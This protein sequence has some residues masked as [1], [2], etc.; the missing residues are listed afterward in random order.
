MIS[1]NLPWLAEY[2][3]RH[4]CSFNWMSQLLAGPR[5]CI[6]FG[7]F[8]GSLFPTNERNRRY[9]RYTQLPVVYSNGSFT[10]VIDSVI[11]D[12]NDSLGWEWA[13][14]Y[15]HSCPVHSNFFSNQGY[16]INLNGRFIFGTYGP[17][18]GSNNRRNGGYLNNGYYFYKDEDTIPNP[19]GNGLGWKDKEAEWRWPVTVSGNYQVYLYYEANPNNSD[20]VN[21]SLHRVSLS[22]G[23]PNGVLARY[24]DHISQQT[25][26]R[27]ITNWEQIFNTITLN[28]GEM[29]IVNLQINDDAT[30][31]IGDR[32]VDAIRFIGPTD[33]VV[34]AT[35]TPTI[36]DVNNDPS[37]I[38]SAEGFHSS[39]DVLRG[40][41][42]IGNEPGGG[43]ISKT[44]FFLMTACD[45]NNFLITFP[46]L[47]KNIGN[48]YALRDNGLICMGAATADQPF[49]QDK[50]VF[51]D[52]VQHGS[53]FGKAFLAQSNLHF[54]FPQYAL[55]GAGTLHAQPYIQYGSITISNRVINSGWTQFESN[56]ILIR[57]VTVNGNG[58]WDLTS[59][60]N[61]WSPFGT[62]AEIIVRPET[63]FSP[64]GT[65]EVHLHAVNQ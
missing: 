64:T 57:N 52:S 29:A 25:H 51:I 59:C 65:N 7:G 19:F 63:V 47:N 44:P 26:I 12:S 32:I 31:H 56:P 48:Q 8:N 2:T 55:L 40:F 21:L 5:G 35:Q 45:I 27:H 6:N 49:P 54:N 33:H 16:N 24:D 10:A 30:A 9:C 60:H 39:D 14:L 46:T 37:G 61:S 22:G 34:Q 23:L 17:F 42:D 28:V 11:P 15:N 18:W 41:E 1:L 62:H 20:S 43:G 3:G 50:K 4:N 38:F 58:N 36:T 53:D 13:G